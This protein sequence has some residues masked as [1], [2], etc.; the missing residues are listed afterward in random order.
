MRS[1]RVWTRLLFSITAVALLGTA[2]CEEDDAVFTPLT[3]ETP[4]VVSITNV[5]V[6]GDTL[7][8][9]TEPEKAGGPES[10]GILVW[11]RQTG[12]T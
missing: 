9:T 2:A 4:P 10:A 11:K 12:R 1:A 8:L 7:K 5:Q 6:N 3:D